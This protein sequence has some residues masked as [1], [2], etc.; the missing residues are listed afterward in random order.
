M[1]KLNSITASVPLF[2]KSNESMDL[3]ALEKYLDI[4]AS[5]KHTQ[6]FYLMAY[7]SRINLLDYEEILDLN[8]TVKEL[9]IKHNILYTLCPPYKATNMTVERFLGNFR[10]DKNLFGVSML[11]PERVYLNTDVILDYF[12]I[13]NKHNMK[14]LFH[15][16]KY[17]S[18]LD[19]SLVD[20]DIDI[21]RNLEKN[22]DICAVKEDSK[23]DLLTGQCL[24]KLESNIILA[25]GGLTQAYR[26]IDTK[27]K[28]WLAGVSL[29][30]PDIASLEH[31]IL[32]NNNKEAITFFIEHIEEPF[33]SL[34]KKYG[35]HCVHKAL[36][37]HIHNLPFYERKPMPY[38]LDK[39]LIDVINTWDKTINP[40]IEK[41]IVTYT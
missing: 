23:N 26:F 4:V 28:S 30:R 32:V 34:C 27:P 14:T 3:D 10:P 16:M 24:E 9:A 21:I 37:H 36:L 13:P 29:I 20:W 33:F 2:F 11:F 1:K 38:L 8:D 7:N 19:G 22:I 41:L 17:V 5:H 18:G 31:S 39:E 6:L 15:E 40:A 12:S 25:G 35:W